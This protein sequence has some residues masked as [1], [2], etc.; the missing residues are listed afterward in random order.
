MEPVAGPAAV[1][2]TRRITY[3]LGPDDPAP[4]VDGFLVTL[5]KHG[6][7]STVYHI[8]HVR[9]VASK[10]A[11]RFALDVYVAHDLKA[12]TVVQGGEILVKGVPAWR[13]VWY[14]RGPRPT[15]LDPLAVTA[16]QVFGDFVARATGGCAVLV[17]R[18][19]E[20][21]FLFG[22]WSDL[23]NAQRVLG[24]CRL[25]EP[26]AFTSYWRACPTGHWS[27]PVTAPYRLPADCLAGDIV[28]AF[29]RQ[30]AAEAVVVLY[31]LSDW[32]FLGSAICEPNH[33][34]WLADLWEQAA[35]QVYSLGEN[36]LL[37]F[38]SFSAATYAEAVARAAAAQRVTA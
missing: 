21:L 37:D 5:T 16:E 23:A 28:Q 12:H 33:Q 36:T 29:R 11:R 18:R 13:L 1:E 19:G 15:L 14:P 24:L 32:D 25:L 34:D 2:R 8:A 4:V 26:Q 3:D 27:T 20:E 35:G 6:A 17:A 9:Q 22:Q 38:N 31:Y 30:V 7:V 10:V